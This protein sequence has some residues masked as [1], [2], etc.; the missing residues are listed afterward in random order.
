VNKFGA[1]KT[2]C[3]SDH[4]HASGIEARRCN[5]LTVKEAAGE[6]T[7]LVQQPV[8]PI[9]ID[10]IPV[11]KVILDHSYRMAASG[12]Q[13]IEDT[14][15]RDNPVSR[16]KRKLVEAAYPGVVVTLYPPKKPKARKSRKVAA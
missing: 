2:R 15:G 13:I 7:H 10:G 8:F 4:L 11:C 14:K 6:I 3:A 9:V 1:R 12:L 5:D 16:L